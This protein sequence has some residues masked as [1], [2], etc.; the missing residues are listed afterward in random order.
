MFLAP[1]RLRIIQELLDLDRQL[2]QHEVAVAQVQQ[3][4][5]QRRERKRRACWVRPWLLR[6]MEHGQ[7][8]Q[9]MRELEVEDVPA[10]RN[11][12]RMDPQMFQELLLRVGPRIEKHQT[13]FRSPL[14]PGLKLAITLRHLA[15][16]NSYKSLMYSFRVAHNTICRMLPEVCAAIVAEYSDEVFSIP[17]S[18]EEWQPIADLF[19]DRWNF[20]HAVGALDGKH[21]AIR[22]PKKSGSLYYNYK[23]FYSIVLMALV[24]AD[25][26]F[27]WVDV[28]AQGSASD[29]Q[30]FNNSELKE[31]IESGDIGF[32]AA[33]PLPNDD[34]T[35]NTPYFI[36]GD[37]AFALQPWM[38]KPFSRR[39]LA[40][41]ERIFN[42][43][44]SR[45]RRIVENAFGILGNRFQC[46]LG[47]MRQDSHVVEE[48]V[49]ACCTM[50]NIMRMRYPGGQ[51]A[52]LDQDDG[53]HDVV[54]GGWREQIN[55]QDMNQVVGGNSSA[56][57]KRQRLLLK[58]YVN[59]EAGSVPWQDRMI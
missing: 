46:L 48:I 38:M 19:R 41:E 21:I 7:Y 29:A 8:H 22:C 50:H 28:G 5:R 58:H 33:D 47:P 11:F 13:W 20:P 14:E 27:I 40:V 53:N 3:A 12:L 9:L 49:M 42:Y 37:D 4:R 2:G 23:G 1:Q 26:R 10:F 45:A 39:N 25:Y 15:T 30:I 32:P 18:P 52:L 6:R 35:K 57:A 59:S 51:N 24:D 56:Q 34:P 17:T 55:M 44:L 31:A 36:I 54:P 43:R 16:G